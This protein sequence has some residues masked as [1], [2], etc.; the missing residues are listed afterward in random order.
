MEYKKLYIDFLRSKFSLATNTRVVLD[1]SN[2]MTACLFDDLTKQIEHGDFICINDVI[3]GNFPAHGPN[4]ILPNAT[5]EAGKLVVEKKALCGAVFDGD[6]DR[7]V[8]IDSFGQDIPPHI[9]SYLLAQ[10]RDGFIVANEVVYN[11]LVYT[12]AL[13]KERLL[14]CKIGHLFVKKMMKESGS[15]LGVEHSGHFYFKEFFGLDSGLL[16]MVYIVNYVSRH[17]SFAEEIQ[18]IRPHAT[19]DIQKKGDDNL[20]KKI[21]DTYIPE[22]R[23]RFQGEIFNRDGITIYAKDFWFNVRKSGTE[24]VIRFTVGSQTKEESKDIVMKLASQCGV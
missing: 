23:N 10:G 14:P 17:P 8:F 4:P 21:Q 3:D 15:T 20:F 13:P 7:V 18:T 6:G 2:G 24:P 1:A 16:S 9:T 5:D 12:E 19:Y 22:L 11:A